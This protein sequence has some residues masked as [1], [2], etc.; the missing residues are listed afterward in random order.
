MIHFPLLE[1]RD[2]QKKSSF[3]FKEKEKAEKGTPVNEHDEAN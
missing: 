1:P 2:L 3:N